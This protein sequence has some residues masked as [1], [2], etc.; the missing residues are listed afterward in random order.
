MWK[1][2]LFAFGM[3]YVT[4]ELSSSQ[5]GGYLESN[6]RWAINKEAKRTNKFIIWKKYVHT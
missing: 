5:Y 3:I 6:L 1:C 4:W 2:K